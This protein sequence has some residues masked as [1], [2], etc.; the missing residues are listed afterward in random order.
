MTRRIHSWQDRHPE[1]VHS[2]HGVNPATLNPTSAAGDG[3]AGR[4]GGLS[5]TDY[6]V[7]SPLWQVWFEMVPCSSTHREG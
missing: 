4:L 2:R 3:Q 7:F 5:W 1:E 6:S